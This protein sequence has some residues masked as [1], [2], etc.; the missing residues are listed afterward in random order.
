MV[1]C[2]RASAPFAAARP[3][4]RNAKIRV[5][6]RMDPP[7]PRAGASYVAYRGARKRFQRHLRQHVIAVWRKFLQCFTSTIGQRNLPPP[8]HLGP[9]FV[10]EPDL[11]SVTSDP[12]L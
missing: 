3:R 4:L 6:E 2:R 1:E 7:I 8:P 11:H 10:R 9:V 5:P 12:F